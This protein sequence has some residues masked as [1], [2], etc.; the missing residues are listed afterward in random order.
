MHSISEIIRQRDF[1]IES[2]L[3]QLEPRTGLGM[4]S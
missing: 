2:E 3:R 1:W 4:G